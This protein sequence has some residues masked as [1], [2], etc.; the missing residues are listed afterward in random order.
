MGPPSAV[1]EF[2][3]RLS[4]LAGWS[5]PAPATI[6]ACEAAERPSSAYALDLLSSNEPSLTDSQVVTRT[7][8]LL[9]TTVNAVAHSNF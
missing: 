7:E 5:G 6:L 1:G 8:M 4:S 3:P 9:S 2:L